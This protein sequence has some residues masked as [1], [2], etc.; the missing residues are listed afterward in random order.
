MSLECSHSGSILYSIIIAQRLGCAIDHVSSVDFWGAPGPNEWSILAEP[1]CNLAKALIQD[2]NWD[3][4]VIKACSQSLVPLPE[5]ELHEPFG[6]GKDLIVNIPVDPK[7][8]HDV[9]LEDI[10]ALTVNVQGSNNLDYCAG[11]ALL[12]IEAT[13]Q[14]SHRSEPILREEMEAINKLIAEARPEETKLILGW[15]LNFHQLI[16][17]LPNNKHQE[18]SKNMQDI[19]IQGSS[20]AKE[21][22]T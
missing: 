5:F 7:G 8:T 12:A 16:I 1:I 19:I 10:I 15:L 20:T 11:A 4:S 22:E 18:W 17:S 2:E 14:P 3:L 21:L 6:E 13:A 9:Y